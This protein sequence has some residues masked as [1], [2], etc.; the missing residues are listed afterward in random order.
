M[1]GRSLIWSTL[2]MSMALLSWSPTG[3]QS[4]INN[5]TLGEAEVASLP[6]APVNVR[7]GEGVFPAGVPALTHAHTMGWVYVVQG[8]HLLIMQGRKDAFQPDTAA[9]T[10]AGVEHTHDWD[11]SQVHKFWFIGTGTNQPTTMPPGFRLLRLTEPLRGVQPGPYT[12]RLA[13]LTLQPGARTEAIKVVHPEVL[14]G[15][16]GTASILMTSGNE[17]LK[18][19]QVL[20][21][22]SGSAYLVRNVSPESAA[23]LVQ[24]LIPKE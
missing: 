11:R 9:W 10:P 5:V 15:V 22:Q 2:C 3:A 13:R 16:S 23:L 17:T 6:A 14:I 19:E 20:L 21:V 8:A 4:G 7:V 1:L 18:R 12:V 24:S